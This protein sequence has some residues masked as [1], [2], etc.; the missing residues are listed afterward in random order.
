MTIDLVFNLFSKVSD[1]FSYTIV[2][3]DVVISEVEPDYVPDFF[4]NDGEDY[5]DL[6]F[7]VENG[8]LFIRN[9]KFKV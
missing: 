6:D 2:K 5:V 8:K 9:W 7:K 3:D 1:T 4:P